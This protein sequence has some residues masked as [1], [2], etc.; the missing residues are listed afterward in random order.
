MIQSRP[1]MKVGC[2]GFVVAQRQYFRLFEV[3]E[4]QQTFYRL[5]RLETAAKWRSSAPDGFEFTMKASQ[6]ITHE[7]SSPTYRRLGRRIDPSHYK[8]YGRFRNTPEVFEAW[9]Q[10]AAFGVALGATL[11]VFQ[12]P[13]SFRSSV[14]N[15][16]NLREFFRR[17]DRHGLHLAWEPR[18]DWP[19][20]LVLD[21][22]S[23]FELIHCVDPLKNQPVYGDFQYFRLHGIT[24]YD[25]RYSDAELDQIHRWAEQKPSYVMFNNTWMKEDALRFLGGC[26]R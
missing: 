17:I 10:T 13:A 22:C 26:D 8:C 9:E 15:V 3:I 1:P 2:C 21:L 11:V 18:G 12:C 19:P 25:Y 23:E 20:E 4:I 24:G 7:P 6:L 16:A 14:E 5:P